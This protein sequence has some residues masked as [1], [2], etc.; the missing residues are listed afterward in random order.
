M[1]GHPDAFARLAVQ[2]TSAKDPDV[3][4]ELLDQWLEM[5]DL[6]TDHDAENW[7]FDTEKWM[8]KERAEMC[9]RAM[10]SYSQVKKS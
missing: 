9:K 6:A 2:L 3:I 4:D 10:P 8:T 1:S 5:R 7:G